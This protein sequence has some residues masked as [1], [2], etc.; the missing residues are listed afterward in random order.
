MQLVT[1]EQ[2]QKQNLQIKKFEFQIFFLIEFFA[3]WHLAEEKQL[4]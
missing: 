4:P 1:V 2:S 3:E